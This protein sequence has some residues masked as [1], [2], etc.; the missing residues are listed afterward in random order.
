MMMHPPSTY[1]GVVGGKILAAQILDP[2]HQFQ[3]V[4]FLLQR[5]YLNH[6]L[7]Q[8]AIHLSD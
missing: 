4:H 8:N 1:V 5:T 7:T 3:D 6:S 2:N